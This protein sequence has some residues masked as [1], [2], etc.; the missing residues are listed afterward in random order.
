MS[1]VLI[2]QSDLKLNSSF[3]ISF[4]RN[5][6]LSLGNDVDGNPIPQ[7]ISYGGYATQEDPKFLLKVGEPI[8]EFRGL[9]YEGLW[10]T[11]SGSYKPG[12][13]KYKD[14]NGDGNI[15]GEDMVDLGSP[16]PKFTWGW[17]TTLEY[18][19][20]DLSLYVTSVQ[21]NKVW[22][23]T[24]W[25]TIAAGADVKYPVGIEAL[26]YWTPTNTNTNV[27]SLSST[28]TTWAQSSQFLEDGSF[29][30]LSNVTLGYTFPQKILHHK[31]KNARIYVSGQN[32]FIITKYS[33]IDPELSST[34]GYT[35]I[36]Q[37]IDNGAYPSTRTII[38]G[39]KV[40]F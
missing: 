21:G 28:Q 5:K 39:I 19:G 32:L 29:I 14:Q 24:H 12:D 31:L 16:Q 18:K 35:D 8:G 33:G 1:G 30:R 38:F 3:N 10:Q 40:G 37:G 15:T 9:V 17:N 36:S 25:L 34:P 20:F 4:N 6:I 23:M 2:N 22:N 13:P 27:A 7:L 11:A 26:N